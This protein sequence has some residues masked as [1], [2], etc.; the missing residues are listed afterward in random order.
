M[1]PETKS[2]GTGPG[3]PDGGVGSALAVVAAGP[4]WIAVDKP[5]GMSVHNDPGGDLVARLKQR[6]AAEAELVE[7]CAFR[8]G[9]PIQPVHRLDRETSGLVLVALAPAAVRELMAAFA[10]R[11][12]GKTYLAVV[13]GNLEAPGTEGF[14]EFPLAPG[15]GGRRHPA[16]PGPRQDARTRFRVLS[17]GDGFTLAA[18]RPATGRKHQIR[19]HACLAG[20]PLAGDRRYGP[21]AWAAEL[22]RRLGFRRLAL[23]ALRLELVLPGES[24]P[25]ALETGPPPPELLAL[26]GRRKDL[27]DFYG[28]DL[29]WSG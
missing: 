22:E 12:V 11:R 8:P 15:A 6:L 16:G 18:C 7:R 5:A 2:R 14:W 27:A 20:H 26:V 13:H 4:G 29:G 17:Q 10:E 24:A 9:A 1:V 3:P 23:H 25:R 21:E 19:R 28:S